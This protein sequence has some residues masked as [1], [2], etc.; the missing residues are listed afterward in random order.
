MAFMRHSILTVCL[1]AGNVWRCVDGPIKG[2]VRMVV[3]VSSSLFSPQ[4]MISR[5]ATMQTYRLS[6]GADISPLLGQYLASQ[7][8]SFTPILLDNQ[9]ILSWTYRKWPASWTGLWQWPNNRRD[10]HRNQPGL[11]SPVPRMDDLADN[12]KTWSSAVERPI[13]SVGWLTT[14]EIARM[15]L[16]VTRYPISTT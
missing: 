12:R 11:S 10:R 4:N 6:F 14:P 9:W 2:W 16:S 7:N 3:S 15:R 13:K 8:P 5:T 1:S